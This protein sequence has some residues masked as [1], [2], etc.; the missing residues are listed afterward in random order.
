MHPV[1]INVWLT[2]ATCSAF[3]PAESTRG[4]RTRRGETPS[5]AKMSSLSFKEMVGLY[6]VGQKS[7]PK[8]STHNFVKYIAA[9]FFHSR[10]LQEICN[11]AII[12]YSTSS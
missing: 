4:T 9:K 10:I 11:K 8:Y 3:L 2:L 5:A 7:N 1:V 12:K 6:R